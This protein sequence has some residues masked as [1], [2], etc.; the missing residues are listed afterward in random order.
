VRS[1]NTVY[2]CVF[3][4]EIRKNCDHFIIQPYLTV[5][6]TV[7][8]IFMSR[9]QYIYKIYK[10]KSVHSTNTVYMWVF[11]VEIRK[12]CNH[13]IIQLHLTYTFI[14]QC[15]LYVQKFL[16]SKFVRSTNT[17]CLCFWCRNKKKLPLLHHTTLPDSLYN[18]NL[19]ICS[20][21][22]IICTKIFKFKI[23]IF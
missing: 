8:Y 9:V 18:S 12:N 13:F 1:T 2:L 6:I 10:L 20:T 19:Y 11:S 16:S 22:F 4:V 5:C 23:F 21:V 3:S 17:V 14:A 7:I 15:S